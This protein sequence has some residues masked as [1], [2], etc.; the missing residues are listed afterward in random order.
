MINDITFAFLR[1]V[2]E[3]NNLEWMNKNRD[4]Y[5]LVRDNFHAF[6]KNLI[7]ETSKLDKRIWPLAIKDATFRFN[8]DIR[9]TKDKSPYKT[10]FGVIIREEGKHGNDAGYYVEVGSGGNFIGGGMYFPP[11]IIA[12]RVRTHIA[13]NYS[14]RKKIITDP[15]FRKTFSHV[16]WEQYKRVPK[17]F[18]PEHK[19]KEFLKMK[20]WYLWHTVSEKKVL[21]P[22]FE[23][24]CLSIFKIMKPFNDFLNKAHE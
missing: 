12:E 16:L 22:D 10:N 23:K 24:Y 1:A 19:A 17:W 2:K 7:E 11:K 5:Y 20:S 14:Q 4:L 6:S 9:F 13:K 15:V 21:G 8:K 18:D 3:N